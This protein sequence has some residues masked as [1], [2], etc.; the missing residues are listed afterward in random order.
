MTNRDIQ[1]IWD[2]YGEDAEKTA[3]HHAI[4]LVE[5]FEKKNI[6]FKLIQS[7]LI[8]VNHAVAYVVAKE[9]LVEKIKMN[10]KPKRALIYK[11]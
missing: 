9:N 2:F 6:K 1:F 5:F 4:H 10:L 8:E 3:K 7:N 11:V